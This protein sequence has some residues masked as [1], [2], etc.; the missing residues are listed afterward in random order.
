MRARESTSIQLVR[1]D[2]E[3]DGSTIFV[4]FCPADEGWPFTIE[5]D[6]D[7]T[8]SV[9]QTVITSHVYSSDG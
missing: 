3:I 7:F 8:I 2:V 9:A 6:C 1:A 5:N 4:T